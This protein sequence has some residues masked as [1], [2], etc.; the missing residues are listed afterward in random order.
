MPKLRLKFPFLLRTV[1]LGRAKRSVRKQPN[2][3]LLSSLKCH[4]KAITGIEYV[5]KHELLL[6]SS[7]D[8]S[9]RLWTLGGRYIGTFGSP[10]AWN[11]IDRTDPTLP[12][13][14]MFRIPPDIKREASFTTLH[15]LTD[16]ATHSEFRKKVS[17]V[18]DDEEET[19]EQKR[20][21]ECIYGRRLEDP[22]LGN[23]SGIP[24]EFPL[25]RVPPTLDKS[26][27]YVSF[28]LITRI[29]TLL[30]VFLFVGSN[31]YS[32]GYTRY[33]ITGSKL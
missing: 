19:A 23:H 32:L 14:L 28:L 27:P 9:V 13:E 10:V 8:H 6:T 26:L 1:F 33:G 22:V 5:E 2:P 17:E 21:K 18:V 7:S 16:G 12:K 3:M 30:L 25:Y 31:L 4:T 15:V 11:E 20:R 24:T 29:Q